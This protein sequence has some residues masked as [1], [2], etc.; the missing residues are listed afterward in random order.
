MKADIL[1]LVAT[2]RLGLQD[3]SHQFSN[4]II[5]NIKI[6]TYI[7]KGFINN[8]F[9]INIK[10]NTGTQY[11][12]QRNPG[13]IIKLRWGW[14][15]VLFHGLTIFPP[16]LLSELPPVHLLLVQSYSCSFLQLLQQWN[17]EHCPL[18]DD[19]SVGLVSKCCESWGL[20][21]LIISFGVPGV[22]C[23]L[24]HLIQL[25]TRWWLFD[26]S[27]C[28]SNQVQEMWLLDWWNYY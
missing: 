22:S 2:K 16:Q 12:T 18:T 1:I 27:A 8:L 6:Y 23:I 11:Y 7:Q 25:N 3:V 24:P 13:I 19:V 9:I 14:T 5:W 28:L 15:K 21:T 20:A 10:I 17:C 26:S 4:Y